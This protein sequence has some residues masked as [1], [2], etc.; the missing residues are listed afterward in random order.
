LIERKWYFPSLSV[1][2]TAYPSKLGS[3]RHLDDLACRLTAATGEGGE[4]CVLIQWFVHWIEGTEDLTR[5]AANRLR[6]RSCRTETGGDR[7][8]T[9]QQ[10]RFSA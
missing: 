10:E 8:G 3:T 2:R 7:A 5:S 4:V 6:N 1:V 9:G